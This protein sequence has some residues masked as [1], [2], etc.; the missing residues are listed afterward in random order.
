[1]FFHWWKI[2]AESVVGFLN[3]AGDGLDVALGMMVISVLWIAI[4]LGAPW[5]SALS[6]ADEWEIRLLGYVASLLTGLF[7]GVVIASFVLG[8]HLAT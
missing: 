3:D 5:L 6:F 7:W 8:E 4:A 1:V 2:P